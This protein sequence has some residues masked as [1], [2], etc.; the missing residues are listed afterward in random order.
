MLAMKD[1]IKM[2]L[3]EKIPLIQKNAMNAGHYLKDLL[4]NH[5]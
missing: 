3:K 2:E 1:Q 4:D 5:D